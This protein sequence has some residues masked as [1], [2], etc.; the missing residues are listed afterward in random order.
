MLR[1]IVLAGGLGTRMG[2][3]GTNTP[4]ALLDVGGGPLIAG[5][6]ERLRSAGV[7]TICLATGH[8]GERVAQ[9]LGDGSQFGVELS[10]SHEHTPMGTGGALALAASREVEADDI[11]VVLNGDLISGHDLQTHFRAAAGSHWCIHVRHEDDARPYGV[12]EVDDRGRIKD[13]IEK[14]AEEYAALV[15][16][17]TYVTR[18]DVLLEL[19]TLR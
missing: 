18:G 3:V 2:E 7:V 11:V 16:A 13:F 1:G 4:K 10:Y 6:F 14:P 15:N 12:V 19:S 5:Q 9:A 8:L 17:G